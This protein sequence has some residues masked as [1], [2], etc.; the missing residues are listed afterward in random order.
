MLMNRPYPMNRA[1][2]PRRQRG[3][4]MLETLVT[5]FIISIWL[6]GSA[7]VQTIAMKFSKTA[8][9]RNAAVM[10]ANDIGERM[11]TNKQ[12]AV[13]GLYVYDGTAKTAAINCNT[14]ACTT[15]QLATFDLAEWYARATASLPGAQFK[16]EG[17]AANPANYKITIDW[18]DRRTGQAYSS[19]LST[20]GT[21]TEKFTYV[22]N[23]LVYSPPAP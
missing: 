4:S 18:F 2:A 7:G 12:G 17:A 5:L 19:A 3:F 13:A 14:T 8:E 10:L 15:A 20:N 9:Q 11:E 21:K 6:L 22:S 16:I 23:K 1:S